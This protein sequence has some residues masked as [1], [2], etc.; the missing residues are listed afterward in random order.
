MWLNF[1][2]YNHMYIYWPVVLVGLTVI[3]IFLPAR[4]LYHRSRKWF[5]FSNV[6]Y[7]S[8]HH[9]RRLSNPPS[10]VFCSLEYTLSSFVTSFWATCTVLKRM[11]WG[12]SSYSS[13]Y[14]PR[15]GAIPRSV[16]PPTLAFWDFSSASPLFGAPSSV[17][18]DTRT[19]EM[20]SLIS[21]TWAS[22]YSVSSTMPRSACIALTSTRASRQPSSLLL[23]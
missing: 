14:M 23:S 6:S 16:I 3:I 20:R 15:T 4:V 12:T 5:A 8:S 11:P 17:S 9:I 10:G 7:H 21:S 1:S 13:V 18:G 2:W 22:T 19:Q